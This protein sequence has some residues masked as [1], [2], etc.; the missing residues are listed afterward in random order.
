MPKKQQKHVEKKKLDITAHKA[1]PHLASHTD[2]WYVSAADIF[3]YE[4]EVIVEMDMPGVSKDD[5][6]M[7]LKENEIVVT[8]HVVH[9]EDRDDKVLY[10]EYDEGHFHRH[11]VLN[12]TIDRDKISSVMAEGVLRIVLPKKQA[13][14]QRQIEVKA[15]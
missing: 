12:D 6:D 5:V 10:R 9:G 3:E 14:K 8:G 7:K 13:Y 15:G 2:E 1:E 11:F 4:N